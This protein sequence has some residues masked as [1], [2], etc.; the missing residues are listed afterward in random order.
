MKKFEKLNDAKF[1]SLENEQMRSIRGGVQLNTMTVT[2]RK[3]WFGV[4]VTDDGQDPSV[5]EIQ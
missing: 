2:K 1:S 3:F 5:E 4:K